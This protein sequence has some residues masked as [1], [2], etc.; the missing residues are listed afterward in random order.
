M[1]DRFKP[2]ICFV[3]FTSIKGTSAS[4]LFL[5]WDF[6]TLC[7]SRIKTVF[8]GFRFFFNLI[9]CL[10]LPSDFTLHECILV[11]VC[12][13]DY[14]LRS[15]VCWWYVVVNHFLAYLGQGYIYMNLVIAMFSTSL[16]IGCDLILYV[17]VKR[18]SKL[19]NIRHRSSRKYSLEFWMSVTLVRWLIRQRCL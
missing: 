2:I 3:K 13:V 14:L 10:D 8:P 5:P 12:L 4:L 6:L 1:F 17:C 9:V 7:R 18:T 11:L 16:Q 15:K 19:Y